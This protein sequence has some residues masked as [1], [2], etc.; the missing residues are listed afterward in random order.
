MVFNELGVNT[1]YID[2][3]TGELKEGV[4]ATVLSGNSTDIVVTYLRYKELT[5]LVNSYGSKFLS[6]VSKVDNRIHSSFLQMVD[7]ARTSSSKP[8]I[9]NIPREIEYRSCF[10]EEDGYTLVI[11][12][13]SSQE[14]LLAGDLYGESGILDA[15]KSGKDMHLNTASI[16]YGEEVTDKEDLRR[17]IAKTIIF[18]IIYGGGPGKIATQ[19]KMPMMMASKAVKTVKELYPTL[20]A[21]LETN[22][23][24]SLKRGYITTNK[25]SKRKIYLEGFEEY[26]RLRDMA[27][28]FTECG[29]DV[30]PDLLN[31]LS[32]IESSYKRKSFNY[33]IQSS[34]ADMAKRAGVHL[35]KASKEHNF[36]IVLLAHDEWVV[37]CKDEDSEKVA[38][39]LATCMKLA[40]KEILTNSEATAKAV[41]SKK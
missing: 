38:K 18:T 7:T 21:G 28:R 35:R 31:K 3:K 5:K 32:S 15:I 16:V 6:L 41:I 39:I 12:D 27:V 25:F 29:W 19:F 1:S 14:V 8:N 2:K 20:M 9:Q 4:N 22:F 26:V 37:R 13:Y 34:G 23:Q 10:E 40:G 30:R 24:E 33:P 36:Q 17:Q 11:A